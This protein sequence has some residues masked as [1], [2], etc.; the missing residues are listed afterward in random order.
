MKHIKLRILSVIWSAIFLLFVVFDLIL[1]VSLPLY[2]ENQ[3]RS[4]LEYE[5]NYIKELKNSDSDNKDEPAEYA[6]TY[7]SGEINFIIPD[8]ID[9]IGDE[10]N[11]GYN[12]AQK[13]ADNEIINFL[14]KNNIELGECYTVKTDNG[15]YVFVEYEDVFELSGESSPTIMYINIQP[16]VRYT[17]SLDLLLGIAFFCITAVMS[18]IGLKLGKKI[19]ESQA[20]QRRFFQ[21]SSHE[22]KTPL[23]AIQGYAEGIQAG[24]IDPAQSATVILEE[25][26]RMTRLVEELLSISKIDAHR[27]VLNFAVTDVREILYDCLRAV[28]GIQKEKNIKIMLGFSDSPILADCD[29]DQLGRAFTNVIVN[30]LRHCKNK[31]M[32]SCKRRGKYCSVKVFNDGDN[33]S[34]KDL[35]HIFD[36]FYTGKNGNTGIGLALT[37]EIVRLH[38][39]SISAYNS[40]T[41]V[42]FEIKLLCRNAN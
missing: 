9:S 16:V 40:A 18:V 25:S 7:L 8:D 10:K 29:E 4:A 34:S 23:M 22:L 33:I 6:G 3:A 2:F 27:L 14:E 36:R 28:E 38:S 11:T 24:V 17:R 42:V 41:G 21:N 20:A 39:G 26:D 32:I 30:A 19:E 31:V 37:S 5:V 1:H 12:S 13:I 15:Y 35:P